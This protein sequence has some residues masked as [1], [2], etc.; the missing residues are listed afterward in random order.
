MSLA[1]REI[2]AKPRHRK[3]GKGKGKNKG[4]K[5]RGQ[6][7]AKVTLCHKP[8]SPDEE[9]LRV[10][11]PAVPGHLDH[12]DGDMLG[13]CGSTTTSTST[14][15][16]TTTTTTAPPCSPAAECGICRVTSSTTELTVVCS[17]AQCGKS[18]TTIQNEG[19]ACTSSAECHARPEFGPCSDC[20]RDNAL[21]GCTF[22]FCA[23]RCA[24]G[25]C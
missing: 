5:G 17:S 1:G 20:L 9:T 6:G 23:K 10:A 25:F 11:K 15:S 8:G 2:A 7:Q 22:A 13:A 12:G 4:K 21:G 14:T 16:T 3:K 24:D 18:C 19:L